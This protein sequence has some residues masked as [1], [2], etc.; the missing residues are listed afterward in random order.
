MK[1]QVKI[2][3]PKYKGET[4]YIDGYVQDRDGWAYAAVVLPQSKKII[5]VSLN[6]LEVILFATF[7]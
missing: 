1:T 7:L 3:G 4:G 2:I 5:L 6:D